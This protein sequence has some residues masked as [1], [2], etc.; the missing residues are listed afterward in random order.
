ML[1]AIKL[2]NVATNSKRKI[3]EDF[4]RK[5]VDLSNSLLDRRWNPDTCDWFDRFMDFHEKVYSASKKTT[6]FNSQVICDIERNVWKSRGKKI[7]RVVVKFNCPRNC[8]YFSTG[9][10]FFVE[11]GIYPR[12]RIAVPIRQ[13]RNYERFARLIADGWLCKTYGLTS[14]LE[15]VAFLSKDKEISEHRNVLGIDVNA[16]HFAVSVVSPEGKVLFQDYFGKSI[17][18]RRKEIMKRKALLQTKKAFGKLKRLRNRERDFVNTNLGQMV[19][20]IVGIA[21][22]F[23]ADIAVEGLKRFKAKGKRFNRETMRI[24]FAKFRSIL[25]QRCF[26]ND[27]VLETMDSWHTSKWC[28]H[29]GAVGNG[30][31]ANYSLFKCKCGQVVNSDRKASLAVATKCLLVRNKHTANQVASFQFTSRRVPVNG[32]LRSDENGLN[33]AVHDIQPL[34]GMPYPVG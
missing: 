21:K 14:D 6:S 8:K 29:C 9:K 16:K 26:D 20:E 24:P 17:W 12:R 18:V 25:E 30:H 27:I 32:L 11:L 28:S 7:S 15:V 1:R 23:D 22:R 2:Q 5:A 33:L 10:M 13:N 4:S 3:L 19:A 34:N 31:S